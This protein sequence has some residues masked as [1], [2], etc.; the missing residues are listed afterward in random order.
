MMESVG[1]KKMEELFASIP[2]GSRR[3]G[4]IAIEPRGEWRLSREFEEMSGEN[5]PAVAFVGAGAYPH[6]IPAHI[7]Y[8][9]SRSEFLTSYTP[10]QPEI[11]QGTL[12]AI[13]EFQ[14]MTANLLGMEVANASMYD[15]GSALAES[16]LMA[17]RVKKK[18]KVALSRFNHPHYVQVLDAYFKPS[19][20]ET[21][22]LEILPDGRTDYGKIPDDVSAV[23]V[24]SPNFMGVIED[25]AAAARAAHDK[26]ALLIVSF[27]EAMAWGILKNPGSQGADIVCGEGKSFGIPLNF[28]GPGVGM[29][30]CKMEFVRTTPG[31]LVGQTLDRDGKR[32]WVLT[33]SAREQHIRREKAVS[34]I[35][36][37]SGHCALTAAMYMATAGKTGL[38]KMAQLNHDKAAYLRAGLERA[39]FRP[40]FG[41]PFFNEFAMTAP[42][43][44]EKRHAALAE[45]GFVAGLELGSRFPKYRGA[46]LFCATEIHTKDVI[47]EFLQTLESRGEVA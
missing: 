21:V 17:I 25:I 4:E 47:D 34:N 3:A 15:G 19:G 1:I 46:Y 27:A 23:V 14:T 39:G 24:Q 20:F 30:A 18:P 22:D 9:A 12:Q 7:P 31:R 38:R 5:R 26:N 8:L 35:C 44:F 16:A 40:L 13:F 10:Y 43:G 2:P 11:S 45:K 29:L 42:E 6:A 28:G 32:A 41:G 37:N 33:L 36:T